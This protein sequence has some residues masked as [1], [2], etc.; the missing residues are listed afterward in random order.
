M[1]KFKKFLWYFVGFYLGAGAIGGCVVLALEFNIGFLVLA[2]IL[3]VLSY[4]CFKKGN[5]IS[6]VKEVESNQFVVFQDICI[7]VKH[8]VGLPIQEGMECSLKYSEE[9]ID[10]TQ[11]NTTFNLDLSKVRD[12]TT[13]TDTEIQK[14]YV[15]SAGGAIGGYMLF[16]PLGGIV[17]GRAKKKNIKTTT[18]YLVITYLD[19]DKIKYI[20]FE[21]IPCL[22]VT[23]IVNQ[24]EAS[25]QEQISI[26][27]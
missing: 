21:Y 10:I 20:S 7:D 27:L 9:S 18:H 8:V 12:I 11:G 4:L 1:E 25:E 26:E 23:K 14:Q 5:G 13:T 2:I 16:G 6:K 22:E 17:G 15:S 19:D 3:G 24:F